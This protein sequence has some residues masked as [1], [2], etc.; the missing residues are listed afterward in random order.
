MTSIQVNDQLYGTSLILKSPL[1]S[2]FALGNI[3]HIPMLNHVL[4]IFALFVIQSLPSQN[5]VAP[6]IHACKNHVGHIAPVSHLGPVNQI[7][8]CS[9]VFPLG[10]VNQIS[11]VSH[12]DPVNQM[13]HCSPVF[14]LGHVNQIS[15]VSHLG[16]VNQILHCAH[17]VQ[18]IH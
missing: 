3:V 17:V 10:H 11:P 5:G 13:I 4:K 2:N 12:L 7:S 15:P 6:V 8:H 9:P 1:I 16:P 14:P 18:G